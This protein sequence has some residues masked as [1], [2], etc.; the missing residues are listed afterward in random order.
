[1]ARGECR[2]NRRKASCVPVSSPTVPLG[3]LWFF[4]DRPR[5]FTDMQTG[6]A[7]LVSGRLAAELER[8][9]LLELLRQQRPD[10]AAELDEG[11]A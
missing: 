10:V 6:L 3:T 7:E 5:E 11:G 2:K 9:M 4:S 1:M 8:T